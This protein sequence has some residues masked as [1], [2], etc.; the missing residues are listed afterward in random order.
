M[1]KILIVDDE[2]AIRLLY[3]EELTG[4]GYE[5]ITS[6]GIEGL[7]EVIHRKKPD[8]VVLEINMKELS[9]AEILQEIRKAYHNLPI[10]LCT[11]YPALK[12]DANSLAA[13]CIMSKRSDFGELKF[14]V[15]M[16]MEGGRRFLAE[17]ASEEGDITTHIPFLKGQMELAFKFE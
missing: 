14:K 3:E 15:K 17:A 9:G 13:D 1:N 4:E 7:L 8:L 12:C 10:I 11:A 6:N 2:E 16:A 5:V